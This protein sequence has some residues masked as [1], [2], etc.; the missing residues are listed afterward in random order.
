MKLPNK[1]ANNN[2]CKRILIG[3]EG[4]GFVKRGIRKIRNRI[5]RS[6]NGHKIKRPQHALLDESELAFS[7]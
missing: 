2:V 4:Y 7:R 5:L 6:R 1:L 3:I